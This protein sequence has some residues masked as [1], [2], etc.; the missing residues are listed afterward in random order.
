MAP[1]QGLV[2]VLK[3]CGDEMT[4]ANLMKQLA[5]MDMEIGIYLPGIRIK[6]SPTD[7]APIEQLRLQKFK[8][9]I[10]ELF[11]PLMDGSGAS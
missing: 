6:T 5:S 9:E 3:Q 2:Q 8:G 7:F 4:R 11:G 10:W 1:P